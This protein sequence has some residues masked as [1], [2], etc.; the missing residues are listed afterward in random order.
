MSVTVDN[1]FVVA[2]QK[3]RVISFVV[4]L[5]YP[6]II[7]LHYQAIFRTYNNFT[8]VKLK[9]YVEYSTCYTKSHTQQLGSWSSTKTQ[10]SLSCTCI[11]LSYCIAH[12]EHFMQ[13]YYTNRQT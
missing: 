11:A 5:E 8:I 7:F 12:V 9:W 1:F 6:I 2:I 10:T 4:L 3:F 13:S